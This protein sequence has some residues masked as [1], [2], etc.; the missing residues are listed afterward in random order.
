MTRKNRT[1]KCN[2]CREY[3]LQIRELKA[4]N[5]SFYQL[6]RMEFCLVD[7]LLRLNSKN[8]SVENG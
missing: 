1:P 3:L 7:G 6:L 5:E 2:K 4:R 8:H